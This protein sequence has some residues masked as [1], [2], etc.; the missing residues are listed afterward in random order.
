VSERG[1]KESWKRAVAM[2]CVRYGARDNP[3]LV[4]GG[5]SVGTEVSLES[6][7]SHKT[8]SVSTVAPRQA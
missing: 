2:C 3:S 1:L 5:R 8:C 6:G 7:R 4:E